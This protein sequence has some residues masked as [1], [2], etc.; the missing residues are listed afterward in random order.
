MRIAN[1]ALALPDILFGERLRERRTSPRDEPLPGLE[2]VDTEAWSA[3]AVAAL[4][5]N[6]HFMPRWARAVSQSARE[7]SNLSVLAAASSSFSR[8]AG[9]FTSLMPVISLWRAYRL[10]LPALVSADAYGDL[11]TP[12]LDRRDPVAAAE[13]MMQRARE[14]GAAA[15]VLRALPLEGPV[16]AAFN[17]ALARHNMAPTILAQHRRATL[18]ASL[19]HESLMASYSGGRRKTLRKMQRQLEDLGPVALRRART[20]DEVR[21]ALPEFL[22]LEAS[23]WKAGRGTALQNHD[24]DLAFIRDAAPAMAADGACEIVTLT[25]ADKPVASCIL[26]RQNDRIFCFKIGIDEDYARFSPGVQLLNGITEQFCDD[27]GIRLA[28]SMAVEGHSLMEAYWPARM[29]VGDVLVPLYDNDPVV[30][31]I[32]FGFEMRKVVRGAVRALA[33]RLKP[34]ITRQTIAAVTP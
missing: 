10:P 32:V 31:L 14:T 7:R 23:G 5:P 18:D 30:D 16:A 33:E 17:Q 24:G 29:L 19:S 34:Q 25:C 6:A 3:L 11:G 20:P 26:L 22:R 4:E 21:E 2:A 9:Q 27:P 28:D 15:I 8:R 12:L 13:D 1:L